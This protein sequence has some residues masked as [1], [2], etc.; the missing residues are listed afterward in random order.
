MYIFLMMRTAVSVGR[1][2][3]AN[4]SNRSD[5]MMKFKRQTTMFKIVYV[6]EKR[7]LE[8]RRGI[9]VFDPTRNRAE[10]HIIY[11]G[12]LGYGLASVQTRARPTG[13][14]KTRKTRGRDATGQ[15]A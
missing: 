14:G 9:F 5:V 2:T 10:R 3:I 11:D 4:Q 6:V 7:S 1:P 15:R 12:F 13:R 8:K